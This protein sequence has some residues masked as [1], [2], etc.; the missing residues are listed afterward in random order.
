M[1]D[2]A[3]MN[4]TFTIGDDDELLVDCEYDIPE[5]LEIQMEEILDSVA[6]TLVALHEDETGEGGEVH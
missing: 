1:A 3:V 2:K 6:M 5:E 4:F